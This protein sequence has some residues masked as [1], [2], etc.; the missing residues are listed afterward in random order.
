MGGSLLETSVSHGFCP[1]RCT[2]GD[3][4]QEEGKTL[5][6]FLALPSP[7]L[8]IPYIQLPLFKMPE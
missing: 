3:R 5:G 1:L 4:K 8:P 6:A 2:E 7:L